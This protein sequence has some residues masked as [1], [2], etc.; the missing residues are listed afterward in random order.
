MQE[1]LPEGVDVPSSFETVGHIAHF[2]L[3]EEHLPYKA[4]IGQVCLDKNPAI[5]TVV[6]K[7]GE[8]ENEFRVFAMEVIAGVHFSLIFLSFRD[9]RLIM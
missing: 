9:M 6:H 2:N 5:K 7:V 4:I 3:R 8:V 1:V